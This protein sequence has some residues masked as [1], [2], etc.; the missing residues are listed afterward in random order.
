MN[1]A[2]VT[3]T[4]KLVEH[5]AYQWGNFKMTLYYEA[6][7][8]NGSNG[9]NSTNSSTGNGT[10]VFPPINN[11]DGGGFIDLRSEILGYNILLLHGWLLWLAWGVLGFVQIASVR[12]LQVYFKLNLWLHIINGVV[13]GAFTIIMSIYAINYE[14]KS[15]KFQHNDIGIAC[16]Y[17]T[18]VLLFSGILANAAK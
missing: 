9:T 10:I 1:F 18:G 3:S 15:G 7:T 8:T 17:A 11:T 4:Y 6:P 13:I 16:L 12:W 2:Y 5:N 14:F